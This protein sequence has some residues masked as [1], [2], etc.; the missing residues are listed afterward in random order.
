VEIENY[1]MMEDELLSQ[2]IAPAEED[3]G[4]LPKLKKCIKIYYLHG[5]APSYSEDITGIRFVFSTGQYEELYE[6][7]RVTIIGH[8]LNEYLSLPSTTALYVGC[9]FADEKMNGLLFRAGH[10]RYGRT[11][12]ALLKWPGKRPDYDPS[13]EDIEK[14]TS[15]YLKYG[16]RPIWFYDFEEIPGMIRNI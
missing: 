7:N 10:R 3:R 11:H 4:P 6:P 13:H 12:Y 2:R 8:V 14:A 1:V 9:S 5:F 15:P 16:V